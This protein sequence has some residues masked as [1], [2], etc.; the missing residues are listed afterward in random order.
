MV[1]I[2]TFNNVFDK[3]PPDSGFQTKRRKKILG[4]RVAINTVQKA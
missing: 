1:D 2:S 4:L 3:F